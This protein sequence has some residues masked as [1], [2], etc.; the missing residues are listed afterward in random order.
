MDEMGGQGKVVE[1]VCRLMLELGDGRQ[2]F[3]ISF[4]IVYFMCY[5]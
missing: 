5:N 2:G 3:E 4:M 1:E